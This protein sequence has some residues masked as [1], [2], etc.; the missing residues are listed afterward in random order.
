MNEKQI[1]A[2]RQAL[3]EEAALQ[4]MDHP[5]KDAQFFAKSVYEFLT[6]ALEQPA[7]R[8]PL[9][10]YQ[11]GHAIGCKNNPVDIALDKM[12][13]NAREIGLD[14]EPVAY[15]RVRKTG[16]VMACAK[17]ADFYSLPDG[18]LLYTHPI[19][20]PTEVIDPDSRTISVYEQPAQ[21]EPV[22]WMYPDDYERMKTSETFCTVFSVECGSP[23]QGKTTI[24]LYDRPQAREWVGL[25]DEE[26]QW[27]YDHGRT[28]A[29]M[30]ELVEA[31]L[32]EKNT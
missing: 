22:A 9:C 12:A 13:E 25:T 6:A 30:M 4:A 26:F 31:N 32:R 24:A 19:K 23:T 21:D 15:I 27:I 5:S 17:T 2:M 3:I 8:C 28:P 18:A 29:G 20:Q 10:N 1:A 11:H 7:Q 14:Y 16:H